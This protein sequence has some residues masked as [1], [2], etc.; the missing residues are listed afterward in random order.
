MLNSNERQQVSTEA[1]YMLLST[2]KL[3]LILTPP[4]TLLTTLTLIHLIQQ[5]QHQQNQ[6]HQEAWQQQ[7]QQ[8]Q[9]DQERQQYHHQQEDHR[10][11]SRSKANENKQGVDKLDQELQNRAI[12]MVLEHNNYVLLNRCSMNHIYIRLDKR[13]KTAQLLASDKQIQ[14]PNQQTSSPKLK[15][16]SKLLALETVDVSLPESVLAQQVSAASSHEAVKSGQQQQPQN[17]FTEGQLGR[18]PTESQ[19]PTR[20]EDPPKRRL[21]AVRIRAILTELY[22]CFNQ[23]GELDLKVSSLPPRRPKVDQPDRGVT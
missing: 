5:K 8:Q 20:N 11:T 2:R 14:A 16:M 21:D 4:L 6:H 23:D 7:Q 9:R 12:Q 1:F 13:C 3:L 19:K 10:R 22:I 15:L 17:N 18:Q